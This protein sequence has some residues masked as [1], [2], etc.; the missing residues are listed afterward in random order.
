M[1]VMIR[2][3]WF[4]YS[5]NH[6]SIHDQSTRVL[7]QAETSFTVSVTRVTPSMTS[8]LTSTSS[9]ML[10]LL[11]ESTE[12]VFVVVAIVA[13]SDPQKKLF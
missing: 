2:P 7:F 10:V 1:R 5:L 13:D 6:A 11:R 9:S 3:W 8:S 4:I 12:F